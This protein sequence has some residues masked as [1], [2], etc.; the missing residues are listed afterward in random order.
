MNS[1]YSSL[2]LVLLA[3]YALGLVI[4]KAVLRGRN[5]GISP[6]TWFA[7]LWL[8]ATLLLAFPIYDFSFPFSDDG[9][10]FVIYIHLA[11][12]IGS[13]VGLAGGPSL[14][15]GG[16]ADE[17][18]IISPRMTKGFLVCGI[19]GVLIFSIDFLLSSGMSLSERLSFQSMMM[20]K[21]EYADPNRIGALGGMVTGIGY[22]LYGFGQI[23]IIAYRFS[24]AQ[25]TA[26]G[27]MAK[28]L[29]FIFLGLVAF[30]SVF[31]TG[32]RIELILILIIYFLAF[33]PLDPRKDVRGMSW[34][35]LSYRITLLVVGGSILWLGIV[36]LSSR[37]G[38]GQNSASMLYL[39]HRA[40]IS[41]T[42]SEMASNSPLLATMLLQLSYLTAP[43]PFLGK[44]VD[45]YSYGDPQLYYGGLNFAPFL[46][47]ANKFVRV[48]D[49][50]FLG[51]AANARVLVLENA[52]Y[53]G[54]VW[55]TFGR[56]LLV[57]FGI[58]GALAFCFFL[59]V[60]ANTVRIRLWHRRTIQLAI[61][62]VLIRL[63]LLWSL[64]HGL[65]HHRTFGYA[66]TLAVMLVVLAA[67]IGII[68]KKRQPGI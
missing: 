6:L 28:R 64:A 66:F 42:L 18:Q 57:D 15:D 27:K 46:S 37:V 33:M 12:M 22:F 4:E 56:E 13:L 61:L 14:N 49:P 68:R 20:I 10:Y 26:I 29:C 9:Y 67:F 24:V 40:Y 51:E 53:F 35:K 48:L 31:I 62:Y 2:F 59:G 1:T 8:I 41:N 54:N 44:F 3:I 43:I 36:M 19:L 5:Y 16:V 38:G 11:F 52:G 63:Q 39:V 60:V 45:Y 25:G 34:R 50:D 55:G 30:N 23:G 32:G 17:I 58:S 65:F 21:D 7:S 47:F